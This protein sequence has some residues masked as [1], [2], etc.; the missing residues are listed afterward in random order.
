[1][2]DHALLSIYEH[3]VLVFVVWLQTSASPSPID[4]KRHLLIFLLVFEFVVQNED[5]IVLFN[6]GVN[7]LNLNR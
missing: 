3:L 2:A 5:F 7:R 4:S 6:S 1:M